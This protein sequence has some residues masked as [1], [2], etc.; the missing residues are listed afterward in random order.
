MKKSSIFALTLS[1]AF[2]VVAFGQNNPRQTTQAEFNGK[3]VSINY[4]RPSLGHYTIEQELGRK[5]PTG[6]YWRLGAD[7]STTFTSG[8]TLKFGNVSVPA[9]TYSLWAEHHG[10]GDWKLVFNTQ[11]GQWGTQHDPSK[12]KYFVPLTEGKTATPEQRV[13]ITIRRLSDSHGAIDIVWGDLTLRTH[14]TRA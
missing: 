8:T 11:H 3:T 12:D 10:N 13:T 6:N 7:T 14:F 1:L 2:A 5:G 4:G 9:G